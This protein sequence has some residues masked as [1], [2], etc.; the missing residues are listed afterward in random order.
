MAIREEMNIT[1]AIRL[2]AVVLKKTFV[3]LFVLLFMHI[4]AVQVTGVA[5]SYFEAMSYFVLL[6]MHILAVQVTGVAMSYFEAGSTENP[7]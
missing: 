4:L 1:I 3:R 2:A 6:F 5:M 7:N